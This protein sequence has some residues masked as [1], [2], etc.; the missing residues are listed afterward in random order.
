MDEL[1][2]WDELTVKAIN[3]EWTLRYYNHIMNL[4]NNQVDESIKWLESDDAKELFYGEAEYQHEL[5]RAL[6]DQWDEIL[7]NKYPSIEALLQEVYYRGKAKGYTEMRE[8]IRFTDTDK[9]ALEFVR[10]YNFG[11]IRKIDSDTRE[12]IRNTITSAVISGE[13]PRSV[14]SK[15]MDTVGTRLEGSTFTPA[16]RA[17]MIA[18]T[19]ISRTQNTGILQ[20][21]VNEGYTEVKIL[22]AED[23][24]V[25]YTCLMAAYEFNED[26]QVIYS[27]HIKERVHKITNLVNSNNF[28]PLHPNCRCTYLSIWESKGEPQENFFVVNLMPFNFNDLVYYDEDLE[29]KVLSEDLIPEDLPDILQRSLLDFDNFIE[30]AIWEYGY[31]GNLT[32]GKRGEFVTDKQNDTVNIR[33]SIPCGE[34]DKL[35]ATHNHLSDTPFNHEDFISALSNKN[36]RY[37]VVHTPDYVFIANFKEDAFNHIDEIIKEVKKAYGLGLLQGKN[38]GTYVQGRHI[39]K[40]YKNNKKLNKYMEFRGIEK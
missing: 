40:N 20:S 7:E 10:D 32:T 11:L 12:H 30:K 9:L 31:V 2:Y 22:T 34:N 23:D 33:T 1:D 4:L 25:C 35:I 5:F 28:V 24:N 27:N 39:W 36:T 3:D 16:Q 19:E 6:E 8:H 38:Y 17:V 14:A 21:Y 13:N 15:I 18:R 29:F 37:M 26:T